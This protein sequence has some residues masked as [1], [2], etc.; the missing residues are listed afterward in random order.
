MTSKRNERTTVN[1]LL[2]VFV[3]LVTIVASGPPSARAETPAAIC[4]RIGTDDVVRP[5][6]QGPVPAVNRMFG[7]AMPTRVVM[8]TTV[9]RCAGGHV[10]VCTVGANLPCG[11]ANTS[12]MPGPGSVDWCRDHPDA[13]SIP[14]VATGH[15]TIFTWRCRS[16]T[17]LI[18]RQAREVDT[19]GFVS[20]YWKRLR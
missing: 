2:L 5:I 19:R 7:T 13:T 6:P 15:D 11:R 3:A 12:R 20:Q 9:F 1:R 16:G 4:A 17:P 18:D 10:L 8:S 14:A